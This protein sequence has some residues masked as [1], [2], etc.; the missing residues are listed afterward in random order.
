MVTKE[1]VS[2][3]PLRMPDDLKERVRR[4]AKREGRSMNAQIV[5]NLRAIYRS[6]E[7]KEAAQ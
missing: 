6:E 5:Q 1:M 3:F 2:N 7:Q 4:E